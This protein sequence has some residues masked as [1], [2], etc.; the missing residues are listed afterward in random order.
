MK[1]KKR[2]GDEKDREREREKEREGEREKGRV[3]IV[4]K[5]K[6]PNRF[7][8]IFHRKVFVYFQCIRV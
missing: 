5:E 1:E 4:R 2:E 3:R 7:S 6:I 8:L